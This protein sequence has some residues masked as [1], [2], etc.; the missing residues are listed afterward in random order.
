MN[1]RDLILALYAP[2]ITPEFEA[3]HERIRADHSLVDECKEPECIV[4]GS[5]I[6]PHG[7]P[8]H[9]HHD[10]CPVCSYEE[11]EP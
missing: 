6:C 1:V 8:L 2:D 10:G 11:L 5:I 3:L 9:F 4:C 7:E